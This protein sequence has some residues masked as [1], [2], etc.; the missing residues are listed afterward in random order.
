MNDMHFKS[1]IS[2]LKLLVL[3]LISAISWNSLAAQTQSAMSVSS[4]PAQVQ[5]NF[6]FQLFQS[7]FLNVIEPTSPLFDEP[8]HQKS[9]VSRIM[10][11]NFFKYETDGQRA[12]EGTECDPDILNSKSF[13]GAD[14]APFLKEYFLKCEDQ[15]VYSNRWMPLATYRALMIRMD[16]ADY[17]YGRVVFFNFPHGV[18]L[19]GFLALKGDW[20]KRPLVILRTGIFGN[21]RL[22]Q[23]ERFFFQYLFEQAPFNVL[24]LESNTSENFLGRNRVLQIAGFDEGVQDFEIARQLQKPEEPLSQIISEVHLAAHSM[25]GHGLFFASLLNQLN[26][27][28]D[29]VISSGVAFCP[30][31]DFSATLA[32]LEKEDK[33]KD[34]IRNWVDK[35]FTSIHEFIP[36]APSED[37]VRHLRQV[38][39]ENY[40]GPLSLTSDI[41]LP[42]DLQK[43]S[44]DFWQLND[45][46]PYFK[47]NE[48]PILEF[49]AVDDDVVPPETNALRLRQLAGNADIVQV[50]MKYGYHCSVAGSYLAKPMAV[51]VKKYLLAHSHHFVPSQGSFRLPGF[52]GLPDLH[53]IFEVVPA[54]DPSH[55]IL[56]I[57]KSSDGARIADLPVSFY[58]IGFAPTDVNGGR[59]ILQR[60][61]AANS[62]FVRD[63][64]DLLLRWDY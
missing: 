33:S 28:T 26:K 63:G 53:F 12:P 25:G 24:M 35:R 41:R 62:H 60:W 36:A 13:I 57:F 64:A 8:S 31:T 27:T 20:K 16:T 61:F 58:E 1:G 59:Y 50:P 56:R 45:F 6:N 40:P 30:L 21:A 23:G 49:Y 38:L 44:N 39:T 55:F 2:R 43:K 34:W 10:G 17:P 19:K 52:G 3:L 22:F 47:G 11:L 51:I 18:K 42:Q 48:T 5:K 4:K 29:P 54:A 32:G 14:V 46:W 15:F 7:S 9:W 37:V